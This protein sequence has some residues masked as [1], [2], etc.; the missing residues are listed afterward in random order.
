MRGIDGVGSSGK[1]AGS[2][3]LEAGLDVIGEMRRTIG[4]GEP[5]RG[6]AFRRG[7][8]R[9]RE[10]GDLIAAAQP[11]DWS[12]PGAAAYGHA[13]QRH[14]HRVTAVAALDHAAHIVLARQADQILYQRH[15]IEDQ[16]ER[17]ARLSR[18]SRDITTAPG[19]GAAL[20]ATFEI[21]AVASALDACREALDGLVRQ[22]GANTDDLRG[23]AAD[24]AALDDDDALLHDVPSEQDENDPERDEHHPA[25]DEHDP[26]G[27]GEQD[28]VD[29]RAEAATVVGAAG[30]PPAPAGG[31]GAAS[32]ASPAAV[33]AEAMSALTSSV[34]AAGGMIGA[35][36]APIAAALAG[37]AGTATQAVQAAQSAPTQ[38]SPLEADERDLSSDR[39]ADLEDDEPVFE[40][41]DDHRG[42]HDTVAAPETD[43]A[44]TDARAESPPPLLPPAVPSPAAPIRPPT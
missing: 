15:A 4:S 25:R 7:A 18:T 36:V 29:P 11:R 38:S 30:P 41:G 42:E 43:L 22:V 14:C 9:F 19:V 21:A 39:P 35:L 33:P 3:V 6:E 12:G 44:S 27:E 28:N 37:V 40:P 24:Y 32:E 16:A 13:N 31:A 1:G 2:S 34:G 26:V 5:E 17:L 10:A 8:Q 20:K 23:I